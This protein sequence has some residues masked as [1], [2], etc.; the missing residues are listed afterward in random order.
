MASAPTVRNLNKLVTQIGSSIKPQLSLINQDIK[1]NAKAGEAQI[2]GLGAQKD[3]A[4]QDIT[5]QA[6]D[7]GMYFSGFSPDQQAKYTA[8]TYL[9]ALAQLQATIAS[10]RSQLLGKKADLQQGVYD[11]AFATRESD[12][13]NLRD[14]KKMTADQQFQARQAALDRDF[15]ASE[16]SKDRAAAAA[17]AA[18]SNEP[19][20]AAVLDAD[21]RAVASELS[22]VTGGDGYV[23]P[24]S[25]ATMKN[26]WTSAGYDPK[27]F[28][29]YFA[30]YRNPENTAYKLTKK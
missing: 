4:F 28:D 22:K 15:Q 29:K 13:A 9:P 17:N 24:G 19:D 16:S 27:T 21:R 12:I 14:W 23:S 3:Q 2:A 8:G 6:N 18:R 7:N 25:Y 11:K 1:A 10:T 5:Q 30:S 26:Q 20:P